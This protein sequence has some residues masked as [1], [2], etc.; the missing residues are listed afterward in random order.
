MSYTNKKRKRVTPGGWGKGVAHILH[1]TRATETELVGCVQS[2]RLVFHPFACLVAQH[3]TCACAALVLSPPS[4][5][6]FVALMR[7]YLVVFVP[8]LSD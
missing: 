6:H 2:G 3:V 4:F 7:E 1:F 5:P 8:Q